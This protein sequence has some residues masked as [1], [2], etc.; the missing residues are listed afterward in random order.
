MKKIFAIICILTLITLCG[1]ETF[2]G[3]GKDVKK[4]GGWVEETAEKAT[5]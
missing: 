1:C 2:R 3:F 4:A 5:K